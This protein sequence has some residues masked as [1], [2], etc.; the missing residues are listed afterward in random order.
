MSSIESPYRGRL[1]VTRPTTCRKSSA[2]SSTRPTGSGAT[3]FMAL[4]TDGP[5]RMVAGRGL[6]QDRRRWPAGRHHSGSYG[7]AG[8]DLVAA[9]LVLQ[10]FSRW[11]H[12]MALSWVAHD[13]LCANNLYRNGSEAQRRKWLPDLC[14]GRKIGCLA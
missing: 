13:N 1:R 3:N 5:R 14:S 4:G 11:N 8:L 2:P 9:G 6:P 12:A 10:G 7:G